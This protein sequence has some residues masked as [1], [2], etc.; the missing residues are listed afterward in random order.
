MVRMSVPGFVERHVEA[1]VLGRV[2][3]DTLF[4]FRVCVVFRVG[5]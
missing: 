3:A 4:G 1:V 5:N 2:K